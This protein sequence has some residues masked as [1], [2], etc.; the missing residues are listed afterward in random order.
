M[1]NGR[2]RSA[3]APHVSLWMSIFLVLLCKDC[4]WWTSSSRTPFSDIDTH[5]ASFTLFSMVAMTRTGV[6]RHNK[7]AAGWL[8][9][10]ITLEGPPGGLELMLSEHHV[11][12]IITHSSS[13]LNRRTVIW[14]CARQCT[15]LMVA[16]WTASSTK[17]AFP[18]W[19]YFL[20]ALSDLWLP[21]SRL[22]YGKERQEKK[23]VWTWWSPV[24]LELSKMAA[25]WYCCWI[26]LIT[27]SVRVHCAHCAFL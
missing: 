19:H 8:L 21:I 11:V 26:T 10:V 23:R 27:P 15:V 5:Y 14:M 20:T 4:V 7:V 16:D 17:T 22:A 24:S 2:W 9:V 12:Q 25:Q 1:S 13:W 6:D 3:D 18:W